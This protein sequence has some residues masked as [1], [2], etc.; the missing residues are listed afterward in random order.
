MLG[1]GGQSY[2]YLASF[3][4]L[5]EYNVLYARSL[6]ANCRRG[7]GWK[8]PGSRTGPGPRSRPSPTRTP[9]G[10]EVRLA[11]LRPVAFG[12]RRGRTGNI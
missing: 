12:P 4:D 5:D 9:E 10:I 7:P 11:A 8:W 3:D 2:T 1:D 6:D